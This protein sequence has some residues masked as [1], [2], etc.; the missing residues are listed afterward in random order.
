MGLIKDPLKGTIVFG[1]TALVLFIPLSLAFSIPLGWTRACQASLF[2]YLIMYALLLSIWAGV[3][4][5]GII[6][7]LLLAGGPLLFRTNGIYFYYSLFMTLSWIRSGLCFPLAWPGAAAVELLF[8][9]GAGFLAACFSPYR[10]VSWALAVWLF[11]LI[12]SLY[13]PVI[14]HTTGSETDMAPDPFESAQ[15]KAENIMNIY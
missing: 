6:F 1:L 12:Q 3:K 5:R 14:G 11:M 2:I 13:F 8:S 10:P 9:F 4:T 15:R 7:P